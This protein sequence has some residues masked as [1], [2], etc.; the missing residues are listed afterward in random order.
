MLD[1]RT[2]RYNE[3][4]G[5][6]RKEKLQFKWG[7][8]IGSLESRYEWFKLGLDVSTHR[9]ESILQKKYPSLTPLP[10]QSLYGGAVKLPAELSID[11]L[12]ALRKHAEHMVSEAIPEAALKRA[13]KKYI[14]TIPAVWSEK[15]REITSSCAVQAGMGSEESLQVVSEPE[16]AAIYAIKAMKDTHGLR[17]GDTFVV[18]DAGGGYELFSLVQIHVLTKDG[19]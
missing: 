15:A 7:Y 5:P 18:C 4:Y 19:C 11:Y 1:Y 12:T 13:Q 3:S 10:T 8:Q 9:E 6:S 2:L 14:I 16:A 17:E